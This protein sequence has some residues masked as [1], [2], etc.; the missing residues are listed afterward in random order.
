MSHSENI[1]PLQGETSTDSMCFSNNTRIK[2]ETPNLSNTPDSVRSYGH[3]ASSYM[4]TELDRLISF[5][6]CRWMKYI[7]DPKA[8]SAAG[9]YYMG[10]DDKVKCFSCGCIIGDWNFTD[11]PW[12]E[13]AFWSPSC[14]FVL[15]E[16][17]SMFVAGVKKRWGQHL[18]MLD[19]DKNKNG[20]D[21]IHFH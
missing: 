15:H 18:K 19:F 14:K 11:N 13:H 3:N 6:K 8:L 16:K 5:N 20:T 10:I 7:V 1:H 4:V 17:G 9:F 21:L 2:V 12:E